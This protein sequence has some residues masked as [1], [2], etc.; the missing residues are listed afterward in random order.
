MLPSLEGGGEME[1]WV[2][3]RKEENAPRSGRRAGA[4][5]MSWRGWLARCDSD[6]QLG[7]VAVCHVVTAEVEANAGALLLLT[8]A[9]GDADLQ[10]EITDDAGTDV[11]RPVAPVAVGLLSCGNGGDAWGGLL[12]GGRGWLA[13]VAIAAGLGGGCGH[14]VKP[15]KGTAQ[16]D[17]RGGTWPAVLREGERGAGLLCG[18]W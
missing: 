14:G 8:A 2:P 18:P 12:R 1:P 9:C 3:E 6:E 10:G 5:P 17:P 16:H 11:A 7:G 13:G 15:S 4:Q